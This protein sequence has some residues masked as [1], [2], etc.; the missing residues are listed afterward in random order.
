MRGHLI[1]RSKDSWT[2]V[3]N[4][5]RDPV[6]GKRRQQW[7]TVRG[8]KREAERKQTEIQN[9]IDIGLFVKPSK[10]TIGDD[11]NMGAAMLVKKHQQLATAA[12]PIKKV[13]LMEVER[14]TF[15]RGRCHL[16]P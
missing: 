4:I 7:T 10:L 14:G 8:T 15:D 9:Q 2:I 16:C 1:K 11:W 5:G 3:L 6:T 12:A 13:L